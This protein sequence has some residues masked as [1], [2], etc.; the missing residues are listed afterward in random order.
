MRR[1][2]NPTMRR[3][4]QILTLPVAMALL[5][6]LKVYAASQTFECPLSIE[7]KSVQLVDTPSGWRPFTSSPLYLHGAAPMNGPPEN[8]GELSDYQQKRDKKGWIYTY[9]LNGK[10][11]DGK[12]LACTYGE[13]DQVALSKRLD[14]NVRTCAFTVKE[15]EHVGQN[16][17]AINC[18]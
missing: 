18:K 15:G 4:A 1:Q 5:F 13:S 2:S 16:D 7:E 8:F 10:F 17:I 3:A 6:P 9:Q 11:P 12:W 14:D